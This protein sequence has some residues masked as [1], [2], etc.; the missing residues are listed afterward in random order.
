MNNLATTQVNFGVKTDPPVITLTYPAMNKYYRN[1][2]VQFNYTPFASDGLDTCELWNNWTGVWGKNDSTTSLSNGNANYFTKIL[3]DG[4]YKWNIWCNN[5]LN[6]NGWSTQ[7]N[8]TF[9]LDSTSPFI[10]FSSPLNISYNTSIVTV[11]IANNSDALN[12]WWNNGTSNLTYYSPADLFL[13][14]GRYTFIAYANDSA[15]N[16]NQTNVT[17]DVDTSLPI[18]FNYLDSNAT[19][20]G[21]GTGLFNITVNNT[22]GTVALVVNNNALAATNLSSNI[23]NVSYYFSANGTYEYYWTAFSNGISRL[24]AI[25]EIRYYT[26]N[27]TDVISPNASLILPINASYSNLSDNNFTVILNDTT[28]QVGDTE[29]GIK[30]A[31]LNIYNQTGLVN[32][33][34]TSL[35]P[36]TITTTVGIVVS[37]IDGVYNWF[38]SVF[39]FA[40]NLFITENRTLALDRTSPHLEILYPPNS[41]ATSN[42]QL[43]INYLITDSNID[44]CWYDDEGYSGS[45]AI[46]NCG[47][48]TGA[49][50][51][52][53][54][55]NLTLFVND[56][57]GNINSTNITFFIDSNYPEVTLDLPVDGYSSNESYITEVN[58]SCSASDSL[59]LRNMSLYITNYL[60]Q[61]MDLYNTLLASETNTNKNFTLNLGKGTYSWNC[62]ASDSVGNSQFASSNRTLILNFADQDDDGVGDSSDRLNGDESNV[63]IS[64]GTRLNITIG[65]NST[66]GSYDNV[67]EVAFMNVSNKILNFTFNFTESVLDLS[68]VSLVVTDNYTIVNLSGQLQGS[69][70]KTIYIRDNNFI[71]LCAKDAE[72]NNI[73]EM[74]DGCDDDISE[75]NFT[76][77]IGNNTGV[78]RRGL[79][80][81][82]N[83]AIISISNLSY[84]AIRGTPEAVTPTSE[85]NPSSGGGGSP[86]VIKNVTIVNKTETECTTNENCQ[87]NQYCFQDKCYAEECIDNTQCFDG[88]SCFDHRCVK[89][90]D[91]KIL[92]IGPNKDSDNFISFSYLLKAMADISN[93][94][95]IDFWIEKNGTRVSSGKDTI[96]I[97]NMEEKIEKSKIFIPKDIEPGAYDF[98]I[99][100]NYEKYFAESHRQIEINKEGEMSS[101]LRNAL[102]YIIPLLIIVIILLLILVLR[103]NKK[104]LKDFFMYEEEWILT[105]KLSLCIL[106]LCIVSLGLIFILGYL[107][108]IS[109]PLFYDYIANTQLFI[110]FIIMPYLYSILAITLGIIVLSLVIRHKRKVHRENYGGKYKPKRTKNHL[111]HILKHIKRKLI[112]KKVEEDIRILKKKGYDTEI[113]EKNDQK[114]KVEEWKK[115]GYD[116]D[117]IENKQDIKGKIEEWKKK[118][119]DVDS[120]KR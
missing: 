46:S 71:E 34:T 51:A 105:H 62:L 5:T 18:F 32:Q 54:W 17:F 14:D 29:S 107:K 30:N 115:K 3:N 87:A 41:Y 61:N 92:D 85:N 74:T 24:S 69:N 42:N 110:D 83:G 44:S 114:T 82:D 111:E 64:A 33:T 55:H 93:D 37:L 35:A 101:S 79:T 4:T 95:I 81:I 99:R 7:G 68:K 103:I 98:Y 15:G 48:I 1:S 13:N 108:V 78:T 80:C 73:S 6:Q 63:I 66:Y 119:Y 120:L 96:F 113:I 21:N 112:D 31:T 25:S 72:I 23:Y 97:G 49:I 43:V 8:I 38:Y 70:K 57:A 40:G 22:N 104:K 12:V 27:N 90:F 20:I 94:V 100:V 52:E 118:G 88:K 9:T 26:V 58:F 76:E 16:L 56:S 84:S 11:Q 60:D 77:C 53:G 75:V 10:D 47:N 36:G 45:I 28:P 106:Y 109:L 91:I 89:L 50:W 39:D 86:S 65:G 117:V 67:I 59:G 102:F 19:L 116:V 2:S